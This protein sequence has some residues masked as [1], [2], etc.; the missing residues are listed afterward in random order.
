MQVLVRDNN[1]EQALRIIW[2]Y[3]TVNWLYSKFID[4]W[5]RHL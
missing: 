4:A 2:Q 1:V 3:L 5:R